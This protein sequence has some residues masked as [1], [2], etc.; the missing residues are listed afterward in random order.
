M[1]LYHQH[2]DIE[3]LAIGIQEDFK[4]V[5]IILCDIYLIHCGSRH[6]PARHIPNLLLHFLRKFGSEPV[7][8]LQ[9]FDLITYGLLP[10]VLLTVSI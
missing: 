1:N 9:H 10:F 2:G 7:L 5:A 4:A 8:G 6:S 3:M